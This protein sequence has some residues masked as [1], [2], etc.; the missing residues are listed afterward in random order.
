VIQIVVPVI[1]SSIP[2]S[3]SKNKGFTVADRV[4]VAGYRPDMD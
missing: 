4:A 1:A 2:L 3:N